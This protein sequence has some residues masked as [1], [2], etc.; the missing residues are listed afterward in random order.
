MKLNDLL[1]DDW[2]ALPLEARDL[3][4]ALRELVGHLEA[5]GSVDAEEA[6]RLVLEL[7]T[8]KRGEIV[9]VNDEIVLVVGRCEALEDATVLLGIGREPFRS[10]GPERP[11]ATARAVILLL[12]PRRMDLLRERLVPTLSRILRDEGRTA[13]LLSAGSAL[14]IRAF[15]ELMEVELQDRLLVG[16]ALIPLRYR[17]Y[18]DAPLIEVVDLMVRRGLRAVPVV[19]ESY[20][21]LGIITV[22]DA[23]KHL[24]PRVRGGEESGAAPKPLTARDVMT[25]TVLCVSED[26]SLLEAANLMVN[27]DVEQ[28]PVVREGEFIGFLTRDAILRILFGR[29]GASTSDP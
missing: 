4:E 13:R 24:L 16:D 7:S 11:E 21:V 10:G 27:R 9:E 28:L 18:P 12:T 15:K 8:A 22:G 19:G 1:M 5:T 2:V 14:E 23:L 25:R 20:E 29:E 6:E 3:T 26:Q 17:L